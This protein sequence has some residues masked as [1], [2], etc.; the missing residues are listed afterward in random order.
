VKKRPIDV[1]ATTTSLE[2]RV[3]T[4]NGYGFAEQLQK[5]LH[6][7]PRA[8]PSVGRNIVEIVETVLIERIDPSKPLRQSLPRC[9]TSWLKVPGAMPGKEGGSNKSPGRS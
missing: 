3:L 9:P 4:S 5:Y 2:L 8:A 6:S 1:P 7:L